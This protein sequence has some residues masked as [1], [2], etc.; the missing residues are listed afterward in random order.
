MWVDTYTKTF[1]AGAAIAKNLRVTLTSGKL[2]VAVLATDDIGVIRDAAFADGDQRAVVLRNKA[3]TIPMV[4]G[5][6]IAFGAK[7]YTAAGGKISATAATGSF[8][9]GY[10]VEAATADGDIIE[11]L[12][13]YG[14][15]A[16]P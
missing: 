11:V 12:P 6:A 15:V 2:A 14:E 10:A 1:T 16:Q 8:L 4:A 7:V 5:G 3:G 9:R 13:C